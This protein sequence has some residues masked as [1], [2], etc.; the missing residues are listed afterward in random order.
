MD[1]R[2]GKR[3]GF[4]ILEL[5]ITIAV[6]SVLAAIAIPTF[7]AN[8]DVTLENAGILLARDLRAA[9]NRSAYMAEPCRFEFTEDGDGYR[10]TDA[11][12][13]IVQN[14]ATGLE[15]VRS[16]SEDAVFSGVVIT[17]IECGGDRTIVYDEQGRAAE[18]AR[19]TLEFGG[20]R[21]VVTLEP[22]G[23]TV[24]LLGSTSGW[25]DQGY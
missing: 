15:F 18:P 21:R 2:C 24:K 13:A 9:Q 14:P 25:V 17:G 20:E 23:G 11:R 3:R 1:A 5:L 12:G 10:V 7:F 16:Y 4:T 19:I 6:L 8:A 22:G